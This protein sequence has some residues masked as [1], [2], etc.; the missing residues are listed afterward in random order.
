MK[1]FVKNKI[2]GV[3]VIL[4]GFAQALQEASE[5]RLSDGQE[6]HNVIVF[7]MLRFF[8]MLRMTKTLCCH[9]EG[10]T[11]EKSPENKPFAQ[12]IS[13]CVPCCAASLSRD[14]NMGWEISL[15]LR[16]IKM[17]T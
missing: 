5:A 3:L 2:N 6:S 14:D 17:A 4:N 13:P 12:E 1:L 15:R 10:G 7:N 8:A 11:T 9:F 16:R